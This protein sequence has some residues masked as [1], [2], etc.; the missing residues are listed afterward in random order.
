MRQI[1]TR[2]LIYDFSTTPVI[3]RLTVGPMNPDINNMCV[4]W[5]PPNPFLHLYSAGIYSAQFAS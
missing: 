5:N 4:L 2:L 1:I 3:D